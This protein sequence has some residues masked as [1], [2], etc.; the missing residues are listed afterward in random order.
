MNII[1]FFLI[2][3]VLGLVAWIGTAI[4]LRNHDVK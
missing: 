3:G 1:H 2:V 4:Y